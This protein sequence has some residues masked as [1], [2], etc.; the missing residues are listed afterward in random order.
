MKRYI[1]IFILIIICFLLQTTVFQHFQIANLIPNLMIIVISLSGLMYGSNEGMF[2]G[3]LAG[4]LSDFLY[5]DLIGIGILI[6]AVIGFVCG[7]ANKLYIRGDNAI[8]IATIAVSDLLY[9][10]LYYTFNFMLRGKLQII[11]Y[12][13]HVMVPELLYT[14][15]FG[16]IM[17]RLMHYIHEK[18]DAPQEAVLAAP[19]DLEN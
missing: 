2:A 8:P 7:K 13:L 9:G 10:L 12:L 1:M 11:S 16:V 18:I 19:R 14:L 17:Y 15:L 4:I 5:A 6:F 3:V